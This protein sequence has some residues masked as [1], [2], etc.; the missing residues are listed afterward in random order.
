MLKC[1]KNIIIIFL[2]TTIYTVIDMFDHTIRCIQWA[3]FQRDKM[4]II[5][6]GKSVIGILMVVEEWLF[7]SISLRFFS[8]TK[9]GNQN[10]KNPVIDENSHFTLYKIAI[11]IFLQRYWMGE[12]NL[13]IIL[14][15]L[16]FYVFIQLHCR[17]NL[18]QHLY[19]FRSMSWFK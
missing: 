14:I 16:L 6:D 1:E 17:I 13:F 12:T 15:L 5:S 8:S 3:L 2:E 10:Q 18:I 19:I 9:S 11:S 7:F 4:P